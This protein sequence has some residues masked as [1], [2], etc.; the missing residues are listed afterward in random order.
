MQQPHQKKPSPPRGC[1]LSAFRSFVALLACVTAALI[2]AAGSAQAQRLVVPGKEVVVTF[3]RSFT[4]RGAARSI[5]RLHVPS[6]IELSNVRGSYAIGVATTTAEA[7]LQSR[8]P[9]LVN[10]AEIAAICASLRADNPGVPISCE[11]N[12]LFHAA[13]TPND[14]FY[15]SLYGLQKIGAPAAWDLTTG[16]SSVVVAI[17]DTGV[18]YTHVDLQANIHTNAGETPAN[19]VDDDLNGFVDDYYGYDFANLDGNPLD[20]DEHGTHCAGIVGARGDNSAGVVGANWQVGILP[21]KVADANG[22]AFLSDIAAGIEYAVDRG[23][24][25]LNISLAAG[26]TTTALNNAIEYARTQDVL[27]VAA[28]GN[29]SVNNDVQPSYPANSSSTNVVSVAATNSRDS[30]ASFSNFGA[31]TVDLAA[32]GVDILSTVP[33]NQYR[34]IS[35]TSMASPCVAGVAGLM[36][37]AN[38]ALTHTQM[39]SIL[40]SSVDPK[41]GLSGKV[42]SGGRLNAANAVSMA[43]GLPT[44]TPTPGAGS[45]SISISVERTRRR[46]YVSGTVTNSQ[47]SAVVSERVRLFCGGVQVAAKRTDSS[48]YFEFVRRRSSSPLRCR[49]RDSEGA[50]SAVRT[51]R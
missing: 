34:S 29:E 30:L 45:N 39:R 47:G 23:A 18:S 42:V 48:G 51:L 14:T 22:D 4:Q 3:P 6:H 35:G 10:D 1:R 44:P 46:N 2:A 37:A 13:T 26:V 28:A 21:V 16:S 49:V 25:V 12:I 7:A 50:R 41:R 24:S 19:L 27:I 8:Q 11:P 9:E 5:D 36:K 20:D 40:L 17:I 38:G 31:T 32:P 43:L 33:G 15:S